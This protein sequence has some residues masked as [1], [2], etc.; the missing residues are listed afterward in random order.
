MLEGVFGTFF[1]VYL[2]NGVSGLGGMG[3]V[4]GIDKIL[5]TSWSASLFFF[6]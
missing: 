6:P 2:V 3:W 5:G 4:L 1:K